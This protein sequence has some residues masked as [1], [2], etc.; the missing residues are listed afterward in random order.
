M[1]AKTLCLGMLSRGDASGYEIRKAFEDGPFHH[2]FDVGY[3]SIYPA[4]GRLLEEGLVTVRLLAQDKRPDKKIYSI[5][6]D[7]RRAFE[8][9]LTEAPAPDRLKSEFLFILFFA[10]RLPAAEVEAIIDRR[11][12]EIRDHIARME[13][14]GCD[15]TDGC[16]AFVHG[17]GIAV[18]RTIA[19]YLASNKHLLIAEA[20]RPTTATESAM[21]AGE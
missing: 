21:A 10:H 7:G 19:D 3:G 13:S 12:D 18:Y 14:G 20:R 11:V 15:P 1:D 6:A 17:Y 5:T 4:L 2:F 16:H 9:S 8:H